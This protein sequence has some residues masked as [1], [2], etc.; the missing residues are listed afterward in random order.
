M[1]RCENVA[2]RVV[3]PARSRIS[4]TRIH[5]MGD[6]HVVC[7]SRRFGGSTS[8]NHLELWMAG[9]AE[10]GPQNSAMAVPVGIRDGMWHH[11]E[12]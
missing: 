3:L 6:A 10:F 2:E 5:N 11:R 8:K 7:Y 4:E 12:E 9:F 1:H